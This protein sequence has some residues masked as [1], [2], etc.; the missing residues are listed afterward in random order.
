[1][2]DDNGQPAT[3]SDL[4]RRLLAA[5]LLEVVAAMATP[6]DF[7]DLE[8]RGV[9]KR[10]SHQWYLL[11]KPSELPAHAWTQ[12]N[13]VGQTWVGDR[14]VPMLRFQRSKPQR[15]VGSLK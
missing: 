15:T 9:L 1:M 10:T 7:H 5:R 13:G 14:H 12:A 6:I 3:G 2:N 4:A 8:R 11:M